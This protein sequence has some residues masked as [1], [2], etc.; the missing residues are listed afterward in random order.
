MANFG[1]YNIA[2]VRIVAKWYDFIKEQDI[3]KAEF[4]LG[5]V[6]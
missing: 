6:C 4:Y 3:G 1:L 5:W 2:N